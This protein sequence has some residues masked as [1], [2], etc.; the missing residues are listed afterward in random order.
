[1]PFKSEAQRRKLAQLVS[2]GKFSKQK[3]HEW[4]DKTK[5]HSLPERVS[6]P[7]KPQKIR[8]SKVKKI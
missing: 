6:K 5:S 7:V 4:N 1:M 3:F 8:I 2:E